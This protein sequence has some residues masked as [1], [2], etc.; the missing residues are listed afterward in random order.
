LQ[1]ARSQRPELPVL[2]RSRDDSSLEKLIDAG[3]TEVVPETLEASLMLAIQ[4]LLLL[5]VPLG[6]VMER[7]RM[8]R[9]NRYQLL[10]FFFRRTGA[11]QQRAAGR[12][13]ERLA[14][15]YLP[16]GAHAIG[17]RLGDLQ[18]EQDGVAVTAVRSG[19]DRYDAPGPERILQSGDVVVL[20]GAP[21]QLA[22]A[23]ERLLLG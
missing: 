3:A 8:V 2:V 7:V 6:Q 1:I 17:S 13:H 23:E 16:P 10:R 21:E 18:L 5:D 14:S 9:S 19:K 22:Q 12:D 11:E 15:V 4:L 20:G